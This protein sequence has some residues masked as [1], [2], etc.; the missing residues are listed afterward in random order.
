MNMNEPAGKDFM[1]G[2]SAESF[3]QEW[4]WG[5]AGENISRTVCN[6]Y[7]RALQKRCLAKP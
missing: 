3:S 2:K 4:G 7:I 6:L 5:G 1:G